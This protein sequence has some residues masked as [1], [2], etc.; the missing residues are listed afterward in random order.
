MFN[1]PEKYRLNKKIDVKTFIKKDLNANYKK[2]LKECLKSV[3]LTYQLMGAEIPSI[4]NESYNCQVIL[5][6]DVEINDIK[7]STFIG[8]I[9]QNE[10]KPLC[11]INIHDKNNERYYFA[12]KRLNIQDNNNVI[13]ENTVI[14]RQSSIFFFDNWVNELNEYLNFNNIIL[15]E[16]KLFFYRE[17]MTKAFLISESNLNIDSKK[18]LK[19]N[20][21]YN[22][23]KVK[24]L[25][26]FLKELE[27][28]KLQLKKTNENKEKVFINKE[29]KN[30]NNKIIE[31]V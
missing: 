27:S 8:G 21:W 17:M 15:R 4:I 10:I 13:I 7:N 16:N 1:L 5:F 25:L 12:E 6:L 9:I 2:K 11:I 30:L 20:I 19:S 26:I 14:T 3:I 29:I 22:S 28:L 18:L 31:L 23:K 24:M